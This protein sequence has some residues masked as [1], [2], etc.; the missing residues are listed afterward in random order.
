MTQIERESQT[1]PYLSSGPNGQQPDDDDGTNYVSSPKT[2]KAAMQAN[3]GNVV[4]DDPLE[5][6][7][8]FLWSEPIQVITTHSVREVEANDN[9]Q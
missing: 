4:V 2:V 9:A 6:T 1:S 8:A 7:L 5:D 3:D